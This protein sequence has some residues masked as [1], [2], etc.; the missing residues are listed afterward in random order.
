M[1]LSGDPF[2]PK[3]GAVRAEESCGF[4]FEKRP[5][6]PWFRSIWRNL[7]FNRQWYEIEQNNSLKSRTSPK[8]YTQ[9]IISIYP[10]IG[11]LLHPAF[12]PASTSYSMQTH[13]RDTEQ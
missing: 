6:D 5:L 1:C 3:M 8:Y 12:M 10:F 9:L 11:I 13:R 4:E 7:N 2:V